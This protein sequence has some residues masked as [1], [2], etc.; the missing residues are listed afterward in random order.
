MKP[1]FELNNV[2][3][4]H[5]NGHSA[6]RDISLHARS[7]EKIAVIG[8]SGAGKTSLL[9]LLATSVRPSAGAISLLGQDVWQLNKSALRRLRT[10]IG[11]IHQQPPLPA[12]Q[13]VITAVLAGKLGQ[14]S[15]A[16]A[17]LSLIYPQDIPG[18]FHVLQQLEIADK[19][20]ERCDVL[21]GGQLQR[22]G[23]ARILYQS[24]SLILADEPVSAMDPTLS[25]ITISKL[26]ATA[27]QGGVTFVASLHAVDIALKW[28]ERI[29]GIKSGRIAFDLP[30][31]QV[32]RAMLN[33]LYDAESGAIPL[34]GITLADTEPC[35]P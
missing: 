1:A 15:Q 23:V 30:V 25:E 28:F 9:N 33:D 4:I 27:S 32:T 24:P 7:G 12:K 34:Q 6:L 2:S 26:H 11:M 14:W 31:L 5:P 16:R 35:E 10:Q 21:S 18:V 8:S 13:R 3:L 19:I 22:V 17:L 29:I 20:F